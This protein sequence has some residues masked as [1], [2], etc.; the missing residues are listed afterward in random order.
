MGSRTAAASGAVC[1]GAVVVMPLA[2]GA[3]RASG[4]VAD[5]V[6]DVVVVVLPTGA[7][8][9]SATLAD[10]IGERGTLAGPFMAACAA[11][12]S[13][14]AAAPVRSRNTPKRLASCVRQSSRG[15]ARAALGRGAASVR[16]TAGSPGAASVPLDVVVVFAAASGGA[17]IDVLFVP[18]SIVP[19]SGTGG[20]PTLRGTVS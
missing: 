17:P 4:T 1:A 18:V 11:R 20:V 19:A 12:S 14:G 8:R 10:G 9:A 2:T 13:T 3:T 7:A 15:F 16:A 5:C 6:G